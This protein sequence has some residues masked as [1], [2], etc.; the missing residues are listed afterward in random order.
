[1]SFLWPGFLWALLLIPI[2][3]LLYLWSQKRRQKYALRFS[4]LSMVRQAVGKGPGFRRH[5]PAILLL[6]ALAV[7]AFSLARPT[8]KVPMI[9][10]GGLIVLVLD[11]S[12]SMRARDVEPSRVEAAQA[13]ARVFISK[14]P[15]N[16][17][18]AIVAFAATAY[19]LQ[20]PTNDKE[21]LFAAVDKLTLQRGTAIGSSL[22]VAINTILEYRGE[23]FLEWQRPGASDD[24]WPSS[25]PPA[26]PE[27]PG[28]PLDGSAI[29]LLTDGQN[30]VGP[31]P[32]DVVPL[33]AQRKLRVFTVGLG[34][35]EG[36][37]LQAEGR[38]ARVVLDE[39]TL[40]AIADKT[41]ADY[42]RAGSE[43]DLKSIY[44]NLGGSLVLKEERTELTAFLAGLALLLLLVS[45]GMSLFWFHRLP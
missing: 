11:S 39:V 31:L 25:E 7:L 1:M 43:T 10:S 18:I 9:A 22:V 15:A 23:P 38:R 21:Q 8:A 40:Q 24:G 16:S 28:P 29:V 27:T 44:E 14:Q 30:N 33:A 41:K 36:T 32:L 42:F 12:G 34:S 26:L 17:E 37:L 45:A 4:T 13:A 5:L 20:A 35:T 3:V 6:S 2:L 19:V